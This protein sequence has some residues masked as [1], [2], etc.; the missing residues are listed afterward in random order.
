MRAERLLFLDLDGT[1]CA[2]KPRPRD[3]RMDAPTR[4]VL[5]RLIKHPGYLVYVVSGRAA[6]DVR[7]IVKLK[8]LLVIGNHGLEMPRG[9]LPRR[10]REKAARD[11]KIISRVCRDLKSLTRGIGGVII[12]NKRQSAS[13]HYR[14]VKPAEL[15][16]LQKS[17][18]EY[19]RMIAGFPVK[20]KTGKKIWEIHLDLSWNKGEAIKCVMRRYPK[21]YPIAFGDDRTDEDMFR[22]IGRKGMTVKVGAGPTAARERLKS[23][24]NVR[25][26]LE[27]LCRW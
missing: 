26:R 13:V 12:E 27:K 15:S 3:V 8:E 24:K 25:P 17:L 21:A 14:L 20:W 22:A 1:L 11:Q 4:S 5:R 6:A 7:R 19:S 18:A 9:L 16:R 2:I 10:I 23:Q